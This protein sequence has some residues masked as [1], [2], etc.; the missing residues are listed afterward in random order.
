MRKYLRLAESSN[1]HEAALAAQNARELME[2]SGLSDDDVAEDVV[3]TAEV[4][5]GDACRE[6]LARAIAASRKCKAVA[7][8]RGELAFKGGRRAVASARELYRRLVIE[9]DVRSQMS[10][11]GDPPAAAREVW[12]ICWWL[13]FVGTV[14]DRLGG[15]RGSGDMRR[16]VAAGEIRVPQLI[17]SAVE[18]LEELAEELEETIADVGSVLERLCQRANVAGRTAGEQTRLDGDFVWLLR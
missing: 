11:A 9:A 15:R 7:N 5:R 8:R 13:G 4:Q 2:R 1:P 3:E 17:S 6:E 14:V 16:A 10:S 18:S 12:R